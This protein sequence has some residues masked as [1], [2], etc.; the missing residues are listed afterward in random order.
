[1]DIRFPVACD[2][3][4]AFR[5]WTEHIGTWWPPGHSVSGDPGLTVVMEPGVGGR[6]LERTPA[7]DEHEW[8]RITEWDPPRALAYTWHLRFAPEEATDVRV[9]FGPGPAGTE[10]RILHTGWERLGSDGPPRRERNAHG[11]AGVLGAYRAAAA[12]G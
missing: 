7:G 6:I 10:V 12:P 3:A 2:P 8:G 4:H 9:T 1:M 5:V 11:W